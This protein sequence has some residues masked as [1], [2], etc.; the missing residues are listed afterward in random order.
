M[1]ALAVFHGPN[2]GFSRTPHLSGADALSSFPPQKC[3][4]LAHIHLAS[5]F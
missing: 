2:F 3:L 4:V 1:G 5:F